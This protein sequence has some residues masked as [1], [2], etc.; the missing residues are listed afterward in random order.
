MNSKALFSSARSDWETP[1][2]FFAGVNAEFGFTLDV[3]AL[4]HNAKCPRFF[5]PEQDGLKQSW[6]GEVCW[7]NPPYSK[8][9]K[10]LLGWMGKAYQESR[11]GATV[12][13]LV[14][15]RTDTR[16]WQQYAMRG[17]IRFVCGRLKFIGGPSTAPFHSALIVFPGRSGHPRAVNRRCEMME[18]R[19]D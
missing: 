7:M 14:P 11:G 5:T 15:S 8:D 2:E 1:P 9:P 12:V 3:C 6:R 18:A 16:W 13:C 19:H 4:P 17:E 10:V